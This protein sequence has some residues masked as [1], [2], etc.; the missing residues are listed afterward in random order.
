MDDFRRKAKTCE[1]CMLS[2]EWS[3][4]VH[5]VQ[6]VRGTN[7]GGHGVLFRN[8]LLTLSYLYQHGNSGVSAL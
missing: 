8:R 2:R 7:T 5:M 6:R 1:M 3:E 4:T